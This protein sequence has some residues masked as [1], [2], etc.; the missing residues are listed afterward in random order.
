MKCYLAHQKNNACSS[1]LTWHPRKIRHPRKTQLL[2]KTP[3]T[4]QLENSDVLTKLSQSVESN[5]NKAWIKPGSHIPPTNLQRSHRSQLTTF[6]DLFQWV[7]S[8]SRW[9][10]DV[11]KLA[12]NA[13]QIGAVFNQYGSNCWFFVSRHEKKI[14]VKLSKLFNR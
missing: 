3:S 6:G 10:T 5:L 1:S 2:H 14:K 7:P 13:N 12:R 9:I 4:H 11:L 8:A